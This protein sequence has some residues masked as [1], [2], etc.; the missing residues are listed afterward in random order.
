MGGAAILWD[1]TLK[2]LFVVLALVGVSVVVGL[3]LF[4]EA[5]LGFVKVENIS[6]YGDRIVV[7]H[8]CK[9]IVGVIGQERAEYTK[10]A[11]QGKIGE[12]PTIYDV[13]KEVLDNYNL[14]LKSVLV[15]HLKDRAYRSTM[16][17]EG[18]GKRL[19]IDAR[20]S[21]ATILALKTNTTIWINQSLLEEKGIDICE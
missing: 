12:R 7:G 1:K 17:F 3:N 2:I 13:F 6:V 19:E 14:T 4:R 9:A 11:L 21:D 8:G 10:L 16:V 5:P 15:T 18:K 20:P